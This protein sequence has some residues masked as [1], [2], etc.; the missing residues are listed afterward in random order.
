MLGATATFLLVVFGLVVLATLILAAR[1]RLAFRIGMRN[2]RRARG[3]TVLLILGLLIGTTIISATLVVNDTVG[4][5]NEHFVIQTYGYTDEGIYNQTPTGGFQYFPYTTYTNLSTALGNDPRVAELTPE[6]LSVAQAIDVRNGV[7]E[8]NLDLVGV[9]G[10]QSTQLGPFVTDS[11]T[12]LVGPAPGQTLL[13]DQ[14]AQQLGAQAG[15]LLRVY[16]PTG[17]EQNLTVQA[18]VKDDTRGGNFFLFAGQ[19]GNVFVGLGVA[20]QLVAAP[21]AIN[22]IAVTNPGDLLAGAAVSPAAS[23]ALNASLL[24]SHAPPGLT[25]HALLNPGIAGAVAAGQNTATFF[26][27]FGLF[28]IIA[29]AILVVSI[30]VML[31]EER[32]GEMGTVRAIGMPRRQLVLAYLFEGFAYAAGSA[33]AGSLLGVGVGYGMAYAFS[34]FLS[35]NQVTASSILGSFTV[36]PDSLVIAYT[37]GFL[38]TLLTVAAATGRASRLNIVRAIRSIPEPP[39][40]VRTYT[41]LAYVGVGMLVLGG[42]LFATTFRGSSDISLPDTGLAFLVLGGALVAAR[43]ARNRLVF[44]IAGA[45]LLLWAGFEPL[46]N[47]VLGSGHSGAIFVVFVLGIELILGAV[48]LYVFNASVLVELLIRVFGGSSRR[49]AIAQTGLAYPGRRPVRPALTLT[50]F[51]LVVFTVVVIAGFGASLQTEI[52]H[53]ISAQTGGFSYL[54]QTSVSIPD[55]AAS[56]HNN[57]TLARDISS[58]VPLVGGGAFLNWAGLPSAFQP[59][60]YPILAAPT[61]LAFASD[62][63]AT[64]QFTFSSSANGSTATATWN[65]VADDPMAAVVDAGFSGGGFGPS[66]PLLRVGDVVHVT[67][68]LNGRDAN[69]TVVGIL[70]GGLVTGVWLNPTTAAGLGYAGRVASLLT[71]APGVSSV[72]ASRDLRTAFFSE[73]LVL[74]DFGVVLA[75]SI[76]SFEAILTLLEVFAALG[77]AVGIAAMGIVALRTV[78]ERRR[79]IGM[80]RAAGFTQRDVFLAFLLEYSFIALLGISLGTLLALLL[81]YEATLTP[82]SGL[83]FTIPWVTVVL[84]VTV[85]YALTVVAVSGPALRAARMPPSEAVRYTE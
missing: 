7:P 4:A 36:S 8:T 11:G 54:G 60:G 39:P 46:Q 30:F 85:A 70:T 1:N 35:T 48:L 32:M 81:D 17:L 63:Y 61:G 18:V 9:N 31:A 49:V 38:L 27:A 57:S 62:F 25:V 24:A 28:S 22:F 5:L 55:I 73:G 10:N 84:I 50:I 56:I 15:D 21:G 66:G 45:A 41:R 26:A 44:T 59:F 52:D 23:T 47:A 43:F 58:V 40:P 29:G 42:L 78:S 82:S 37:L 75:S 34:V 77:L 13:D 14:A 80:V 65:R 20:Q 83:I 12:N 79:E 51:T 69:V 33:L 74:E 2:V 16:G 68:P 76:N 67:N 6:I 19:A 71:V 72:T 64:N 53:T 3:R